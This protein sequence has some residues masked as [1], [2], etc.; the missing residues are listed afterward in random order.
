MNRTLGLNATVDTRRPG[1]IEVIGK[2]VV[3]SAISVHRVLGPGLLE[4]AYQTC[5]TIELRSAG[6]AVETEVRIPIEYRGR[7]LDVGY[8]LDMLVDQAVIVENKAVERL[9]PI[10]TAQ[11]LTY[12]ELSG[13]RLG[14]LLNWNVKLMKEGIHRFVMG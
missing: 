2:A 13:H 8:R 14:F 5:L 11:L 6:F 3:T 10:H 1:R 12:L 4:S 9:L 7:S